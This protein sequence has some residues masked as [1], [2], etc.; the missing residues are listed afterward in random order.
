M[1]FEQFCIQMNPERDDS[2][3]E[4]NIMHMRKV[5]AWLPVCH[6]RS[7]PENRWPMCMAYEEPC[8]SPMFFYGVSPAFSGLF[9]LTT[10]FLL[11]NFSFISDGPR[12]FDRGMAAK[13]SEIST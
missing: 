5:C 13:I 1:R 6:L 4:H 10:R 12:Q 9:E 2:Y 7:P 8:I 3:S 11:L